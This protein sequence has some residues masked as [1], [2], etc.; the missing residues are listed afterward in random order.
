MNG[1]LSVL[2]TMDEMGC[3]ISS[4]T[5]STLM[6]AFAKKGDIESIMQ[7]LKKCGNKNIFISDMYK[8]NIIY[9]LAINGHAEHISQV[10]LKEK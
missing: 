8:M 7:T 2:D 10:S 4:K 6:E 5:Y 3:Y 1:A 9:Q